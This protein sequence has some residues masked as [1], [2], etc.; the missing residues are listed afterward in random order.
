MCFGRLKSKPKTENKPR[1]SISNLMKPL[2]FFKYNTKSSSDVATTSDSQ[3][4]PKGRSGDEGSDEQEESEV[5]ARKPFTI[6]GSRESSSLKSEG[7]WAK[8]A[9]YVPAYRESALSQFNKRVT[10]VKTEVTRTKPSRTTRKS[11]PLENVKHR[12]K[13]VYFKPATI[14]RAEREVTKRAVYAGFE[15]ES[16]SGSSSKEKQD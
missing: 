15:V 9:Y 7:M 2:L 6:R 3:E 4:E 5:R 11:L 10:K 14:H 13:M 12:T 1:M 8:I 16:S